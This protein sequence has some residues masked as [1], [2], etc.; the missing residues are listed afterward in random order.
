[1]QLLL[2][3][4]MCIVSRYSLQIEKHIVN[5]EYLRFSSGS[6][7][8]MTSI[9]DCTLRDGGYINNWNF[10][11]EFVDNY[12]QLMSDLKVDFVELGFINKTKKYK[13]SKIVKIWKNM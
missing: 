4:D 8:Y 5:S 2:T 13:N 1:M 12:L 11:D 10:N 3:T 9:L 7:L 6:V